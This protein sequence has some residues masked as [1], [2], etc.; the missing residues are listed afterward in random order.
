MFSALSD[1]HELLFGGGQ[2]VCRFGTV[3]EEPP[4]GHAEHNGWEAFEDH[5]PPEKLFSATKS[6]AFRSQE[7]Y[8]P[9]AALAGSAVHV[10]DPVGEEAA[11]RTRKSGGHDE[12]CHAQCKL[13][14]G[15]EQSKVDGQAWEQASLNGTEQQ[16]TD[17]QATIALR[18]TGQS[19]DDPPRRCD[20]RDP[21]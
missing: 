5:D 21:P 20:E 13:F 2:V 15:V 3:G 4:G 17:D 12:E 1:E 7:S 16:P 9:P 14:F 8:L 11:E 18:E 6:K 19:G 10:T